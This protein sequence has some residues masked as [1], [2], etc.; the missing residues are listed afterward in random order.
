[1]YIDGFV[2]F[3]E[4][5]FEVNEQD[6]YTF[7][8]KN[9]QFVITNAKNYVVDDVSDDFFGNAYDFKNHQ[10]TVRAGN[11]NANTEK[12]TTFEFKAIPKT[13]PEFNE[14]YEWEVM[15]DHFL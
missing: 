2:H 14:M 15:T 5:D 13:L 1:M 8:F 10:L 6:F 9:D 3:N 11:I 4:I 12:V 7:Q